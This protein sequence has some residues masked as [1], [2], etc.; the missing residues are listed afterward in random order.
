MPKNRTRTKSSTG[1]IIHS[2]PCS[3]FR[4]GTRKS[5]KSALLMS[6]DE[7]RAVLADGTKRRYFAKVIAVLKMRGIN[8]E[9]PAKIRKENPM[10]ALAD[11]LSK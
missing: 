11:E 5:G 3:K 6:T 7:L 8:V 9:L 4:I 1:A 10:Q 2:R